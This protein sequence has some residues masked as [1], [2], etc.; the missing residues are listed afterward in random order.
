M[1]KTKLEVIR[2]N[3]DVIATSSVVLS[4]FGDSDLS[5]NMI[6]GVF[7]SNSDLKDKKFYVV[8]TVDRVS[9]DIVPNDIVADSSD[10]F[11]GE[12]TYGTVSTQN[13]NITGYYQ[14]KEIGA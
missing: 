5:N 8:N 14:E 1:N 11:N 3:E 12:Y 4:N 9:Y 13:G 6:N 7:V 2:I 10:I